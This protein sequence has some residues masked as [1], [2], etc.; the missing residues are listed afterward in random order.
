MWHEIC[1]YF[2][3]RGSLCQFWFLPFEAKWTYKVYLASP[4]PE[5]ASFETK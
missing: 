4:Y 5:A 1:Q 3:Q 2:V